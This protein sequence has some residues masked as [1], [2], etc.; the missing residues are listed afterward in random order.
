M[1]PNCRNMK[2]F[3]LQVKVL[4]LQQGCYYTNNPTLQRFKVTV[5][6]S[7]L[8]VSA[9]HSFKVYSRCPIPQPVLNVLPEKL[10]LHIWLLP[11]LKCS[12]EQ[13]EN[14]KMRFL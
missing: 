5:H 2:E 11:V 9:S 7:G 6:D 1:S 8:V 10:I 4:F 13:R 3:Q 12:N 14:I